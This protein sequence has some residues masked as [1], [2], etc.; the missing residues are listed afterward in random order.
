M[1]SRLSSTREELV[2]GICLCDG[3][4]ARVRKVKIIEREGGG[5]EGRV[6][7]GEKCGED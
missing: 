4:Q 6:L 3:G 2:A 7:C 5:A 1:R